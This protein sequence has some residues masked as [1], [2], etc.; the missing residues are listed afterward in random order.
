MTKGNSTIPETGKPQ[1]G[2]QGEAGLGLHYIGVSKIH[3]TAHKEKLEDY[4]ED[5]LRHTIKT[6]KARLG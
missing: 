5:G 4:V 3:Y 1:L 2:R 6:K